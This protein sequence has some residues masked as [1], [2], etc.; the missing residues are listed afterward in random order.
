MR[1]LWLSHFLPYPPVGAGNL[2]R[3]H[4]LLR[5][6]CRDHEVHLV[7]ADR[8]VTAGADGESR[9]RA[10]RELSD[11]C[12][13]VVLFELPSQR[14]RYHEWKLIVSSLFRSTPY[15]VNWLSSTSLGEHL[16]QF[17]S[18][19]I[20]LLH[21]DTLGLAPYARW[22]DAPY[23]LNH[24]NVESDMMARRARS[25]SSPLKRFYFR[26]EARKLA[27][28]ERRVCSRAAV[29]VVVSELD[30]R[31]LLE[32][33]GQVPIR[34][35]RNGVDVEYF[36]S[37][38]SPGNGARGLVFVGTMNWYPNRGAIE[39]FLGDI[40][41][42]LLE[43]DPD[44]RLTVVGKDPPAIL[45]AAA[46]EDSRIEATGFVD[47]VRP[48][49]DRASVYICPIQDGGGTRLKILDALAMAKP[50]VATRF[51]VDGLGLRE[52]KHYLRAEKPAEWV[53]Q[54]DRLA[55]EPELR[56]RLSRTGRRFVEERYAWDTVGR[57]LEAAYRSAVPETADGS[58]S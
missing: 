45:V 18:H 31:R 44:R 24:H 22:I 16:R 25:E 28:Y 19:D 9:A 57:E 10:R 52:G 14:S 42:M 26:R 27:E 30:G 2:Q 55:A 56:K 7:A 58:G 47:D 35:V 6:A 50:I 3:T 40:W 23:V 5:Q 33:V 38:R 43:S 12:A 41:P 48:Y 39:H 46:E 37:G 21:V 54:I 49:L 53:D 17:S 13:S 15:D 32:V 51:S 36:Q 20:D 11:L 4:H 1:I 34:V 8:Q 29:N